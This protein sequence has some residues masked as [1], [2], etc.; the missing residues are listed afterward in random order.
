MHVL[1]PP[2][3][4]VK[5]SGMYGKALEQFFA[6]GLCNQRRPHQYQFGLISAISVGCF[7]SVNKLVMSYS[8]D[9]L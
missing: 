7:A 5:S 6:N 1:T 3:M 9:V 8:L 2:I 4:V